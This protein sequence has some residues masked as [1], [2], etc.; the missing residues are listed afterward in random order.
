MELYANYIKEREGIECE[1]T[2]NCFITYKFLDEDTVFVYDIYSSKEVRGKG[3]M[4]K[5]C[6]D[7]YARL[8]KEGVGSV[9]GTTATSTNGWE[10][11]DRLLKKFGFVYIGKDPNNKEIN[12]YHLSLQEL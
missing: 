5:F 7:F 10:N 1:Y 11:S 4:L 9:Y 12:N 3:E 2:D 6:E 8:K